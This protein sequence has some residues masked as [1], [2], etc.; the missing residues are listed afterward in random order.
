MLCNSFL[1]TIKVSTIEK[2][3]IIKDVRKIIL[4]AKLVGNDPSIPLTVYLKLSM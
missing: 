3:E 4:Y 1:V 2:I